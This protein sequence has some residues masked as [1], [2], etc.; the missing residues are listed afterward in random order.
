MARLVDKRA[1]SVLE[2]DADDED[3]RAEGSPE[4]ATAL[5]TAAV[6]TVEDGLADEVVGL[7]EVIVAELALASAVVAELAEVVM[8]VPAVA[9]VAAVLPV[10]LVVDELALLKSD[11]P[12]TSMTEREG[13]SL[14]RPT[15]LRTMF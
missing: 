1:A 4:R 6:E 9:V 5:V 2:D 13:L 15:K 11:P 10:A 14:R 12:T 8:P 7:E 3:D